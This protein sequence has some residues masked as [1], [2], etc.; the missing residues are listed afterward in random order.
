M[1]GNLLLCLLAV[2]ARAEP[3]SPTR[4]VIKLFNGRNLDG[5][6][7]WLVDSRREDPRRVFTV[8]NR[9]I[10]ISGDGLGYLATEKECR[11]YHLV[12][13]FKWG[14]RNWH[15]GDRIG[16]A[17]DSGI[18]L[19]AIGPD[20]NSYDGKGAFMAAIECNLFQ[21]ATGDL[22]LIRGNVA[23]GPLVAPSIT[24]EVAG[25]R[26][27]DNWFTWTKGGRRQ[28]IE[29]WGRLNWFDKDPQ[30]K[31]RL[32]FRGPRD[33]EKPYGEWNRIECVCQGDRIRVMLNGVAVNEAFDVSPSSGKIL[34]QCEG[35][36]ILFRKLDLLPLDRPRASEADTSTR[37]PS[38]IRVKF[39]DGAMF[40]PA[41][42][43]AE[44]DGIDL[45]LHLHGA[46][47]VVEEN[48][49]R[50]GLPGVLVN[51]T[52]PGLSSVYAERFRDTNVFF[53]ILAETGNQLEQAG[54][55]TQPRFR[56]V[57]V[58]SFSAGFGGVRELL[59]HPASFERIDA[60]VM[61]DS[62]YAGYADDPSER[63][64][65]PD[66][67]EGFL[68]FA[69][70]AAEGRK[71]LIISHSAQRPDGY[72]STTETAD[73]LIVQLG[74]TREAVAETWTG[75]MKLLSRWRRGRLEIYGFGGE[76]AADHMGHLRQLANLLARLRSTP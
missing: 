54:L 71:R 14:K 42:Y 16:K 73:Y 34:L 27:A 48:F 75:E 45:T 9:M 56:S 19:H 46:P 8:T 38:E 30:W 39:T 22:L 15:W 40:V 68:R 44:P 1:L 20:G 23:A 33:V 17:R 32:D 47:K 12:A 62:I 18:F 59:K 7:T 26:D 28:T 72:A 31:D 58:T 36:E 53:H 21:G 37:A 61:A 10:R 13:E 3:V 69:R 5:F 76:S 51:L 55:A 25:E 6:Y 52:L 67:M 64:V 60:I 24:A 4:E 49:K 74:G 66:N 50:A 57:T 2:S 35:S 41:G 29:R 70:Q 43:K 65:N 11:D 63:K